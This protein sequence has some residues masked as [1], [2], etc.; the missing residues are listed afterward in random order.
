MGIL[1]GVAVWVCLPLFRFSA[2]V[3]FVFFRKRRDCSSITSTVCHEHFRNDQGVREKVRS[4]TREKHRPLA[5]VQRDPRHGA[6]AEE[7][8]ERLAGAPGKRG[9]SR[10]GRRPLPKREPPRAQR[11]H[12]H[13]Q[14]GQPKVEERVR[15]ARR[16]V[17]AAEET[18]PVPGKL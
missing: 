8:V 10:P 15:K 14:L 13:V 1:V 16:D 6:Q 17:P 18:S 12:Q 9:G 2:G 3:G 7:R 5:A 4:R 11:E